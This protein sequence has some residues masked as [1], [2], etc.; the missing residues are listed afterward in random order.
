MPV[1]CSGNIIGFHPIVKSSNLF[2]CSKHMGRA[3]VPNVR[4][5][6]D[7][8]GENRPN[9]WKG[10]R[11]AYCTSLENWR[12]RNGSVGSNPT[13]SAKLLEFL[14][15]HQTVNLASKIRGG[16]IRT[17]CA[18]RR[19]LTNFSQIVQLVRTPDFDSGNGC[20]SQPLVA[21]YWL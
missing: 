17:G 6:R 14:S 16:S 15:P 20:S 13:P 5:R 12:I 10:G 3:H 4:V 7:F 2:T 11:E 19:E 18:S 21:N 9:Y 8:R 1:W